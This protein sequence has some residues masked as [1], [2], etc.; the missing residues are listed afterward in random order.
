MADTGEVGEFLSWVAFDDD[1][2]GEFAGFE[3]AAGGLFLLDRPSASLTLS[4]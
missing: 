1:D 4:L 2:V 3:G